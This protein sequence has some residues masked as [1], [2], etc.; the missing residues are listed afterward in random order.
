[1]RKPPHF[2]YN[3]HALMWL[4]YPLTLLYGL[5]SRLRRWMLSQSVKPYPAKII[6]VGNITVGGNGKTPMV[7]ALANHLKNRS[8]RVAIISRGYGASLPDLAKQPLLVKADASAQQVGDEP[9]LIAQSTQL[10]VV[11]SPNRVKS[12]EYLQAHHQ[13]QVIISDDGLQHYRMWRDIE[14]V[15]ID[16]LR[17]FGN[18]HLLPMGPLR[19]S[20]N[21]LCQA[22]FKV[23]TQQPI[24]NV[25]THAV[26]RLVGEHAIN[27]ISGEK[28]PLSDFKNESN[29][30]A[31]AGI[32][33]PQRFFN[34]LQTFNLSFNPHPL[35]DHH[36]FSNADLN[37]QACL[38][39]TSKDAVKC[40][41]ICQ[42]I[43]HENCW[44]VRVEADL[45]DE[46]FHQ[47]WT[48]LELEG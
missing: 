23:A 42:Q 7:I 20:P 1:M 3:S 47:I 44:E 29:L 33:H 14:I 38:L 6:V 11:I 21:R 41:T 37:P 13:P 22:D 5:L 15:M 4:L 32:A 2:W 48:K 19:E 8:V 18:G 40:R 17:V 43:S 36:H 31:L 28:R 25:K 46:F 24:K 27:L 30:I 34:H 35:P 16:G 26:M 9:L 39:M 45:P 10:P 12:I